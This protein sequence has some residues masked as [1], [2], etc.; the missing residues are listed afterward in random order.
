MV[1]LRGL[2]VM[3]QFVRPESAVFDGA[4]SAE[5]KRNLQKRMQVERAKL[6]SMIIRHYKKGALNLGSDIGVLKQSSVLDRLLVDVMMLEDSCDK[7]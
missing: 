5:K 6:E 1:P 3:S 4:A 7:C 2:R